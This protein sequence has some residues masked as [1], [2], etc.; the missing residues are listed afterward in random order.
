MQVLLREYCGEQYVWRSAKYDGQSFIVNGCSM[1]ETD[2]VSVM[3]DNRKNYV[4]C[5][6]CGKIFPKNG[7]KFAKHQREAATI[8]PCLKCSKL[9]TNE[10]GELACK[11]VVDENGNYTKKTEQKVELYCHFGLWNS[12]L[13]DSDEALSKC[14]LRMCGDAYTEEIHD[15]FTRYPGIFDDIITIDKILENG[16]EEAIYRE[17]RG[18]AYLLNGDL[19]IT[20]NINAVG[21]VDS[22]CIKS[23][24]G[25]QW[26]VCYSKKYDM[27]FDMGEDKYMEW[28]PNI[29]DDRLT[30]IKKYIAKLY[31]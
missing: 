19:D 30:E 8:N 22:F 11:Y 21:V 28:D 10:V 18:A 25:F 12:F 2:I 9:R 3:N 24:L 23:E 5:S 26:C 4:R 29:G 16:Y 14:K 7:K 31:K 6:S 27:L 1:R 20:A 17:Y 13:L 15:I